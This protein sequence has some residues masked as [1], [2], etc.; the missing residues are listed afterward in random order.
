[1]NVLTKWIPSGQQLSFDEEISERKIA[2]AYSGKGSVIGSLK[3]APAVDD[4]V[5]LT[6]PNHEAEQGSIFSK[7]MAIQHKQE[8]H[9]ER[10]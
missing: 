9:N 10:Q 5:R 3:N 1:M 2:P 8:V 4:D 6:N 7:M